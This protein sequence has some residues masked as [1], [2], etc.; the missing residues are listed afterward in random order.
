MTMD[1][2]IKV[3]SVLSDKQEINMKKLFFIIITVIMSVFL[4]ADA[5]PQ[6]TPLGTT[7]I[8]M[9]NT[10]TAVTNSSEGFS[11][12]P[13]SARDGNIMW[14]EHTVWFMGSFIDNIGGIY[15]MG[16]GA[17]AIGANVKFTK[18]DGIVG[19][20]ENGDSLG[21]NYTYQY[22]SGELAYS[23]YKDNY[24]A[25]LGLAYYSENNATRS[26]SGIIMR[27]GALYIINMDLMDLNIGISMNN[28]L[29]NA[30]IPYEIRSGLSSRY[31]GLPLITSIDMGYNSLSGILLGFGAGYEIADILTLYCGY[32]YAGKDD[33]VNG[34]TAGMD[35]N[36]QMISIGYAPRFNTKFGLTHSIGINYSF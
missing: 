5:I 16:E 32:E 10:G 12:N 19:M 23:Y 34:I 29:F 28:L 6:F 1:I 35:L 31:N 8:A 4:F 26:Y 27:T 30:N 11:F 33:S 15:S 21:I 24:S 36:Y 3:N 20:D 2:I 13:A 18:S 14:F 9:G 17:G 22:V 25:G 7:G